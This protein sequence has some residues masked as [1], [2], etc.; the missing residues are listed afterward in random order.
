M[1]KGKVYLTGAGPGDPK[2]IT[3]KGLESIQRADVIVYD[4]LVSP[5]LL[6]YA[7][8]KAERI[9]AGKFP[10]RHTLRQE[11]INKLLV[12]KA[13]QGKI[14]TRLK[15]GDPF[16]FGRGAEEAAV[17]AEHGIEYEI[18]P[19]VTSAVAVPA[20]AGIPVTCRG[21]A[22]SFAVITGCENPEKNASSIDWKRY[23]TSNETLVVLMGIGNLAMI[24][25]NLLRHGKPAATPVALIRWGTYGDKQET[26]TGTLTDIAGKAATAGFQNPAVIVIGEVVRLRDK[27]AWF[28]QIA[29]FGT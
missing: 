27:L 1:A 16:V 6:E 7:P 14:V 13:L 12:G 17:L 19:G 11:E 4:R 8:A 10:D 2:L 15:G 20:Y 24:A 21:I 3:V 9:F 5:A 28:E 25:E 18:I 23:A 29:R 22:S 26:L